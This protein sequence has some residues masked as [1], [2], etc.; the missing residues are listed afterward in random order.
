MNLLP[1]QF[2]EKRGEAIPLYTRSLHNSNLRFT[3]RTLRY[4]TEPDHDDPHDSRID[5]GTN[6]RRVFDTLQAWM[7]DETSQGL[8]LQVLYNLIG[9]S[10]RTGD[11]AR[12]DTSPHPDV[13]TDIDPTWI[14]VREDLEGDRT[15]TR[16]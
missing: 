8:T 13:E 11:P 15:I 12:Q 14:G 2:P 6:L 1:K 3:L 5:I 9:G 4:L 10:G 16:D 7:G